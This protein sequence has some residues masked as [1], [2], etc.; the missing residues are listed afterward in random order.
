MST[1][2]QIEERATALLM[3]TFYRNIIDN[4]YTPAHALRCAQRWLRDAT[5]QELAT[6][7]YQILECAK[8]KS[9]PL[10]F[11]LWADRQS[12]P[13]RCNVKPYHHPF[14]WSAFYHLGI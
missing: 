4:G 12:Q 8:G 11:R 6:V 10:G 14:Y 3:F 1:L 5:G 13:P 7:A 2:W 9:E